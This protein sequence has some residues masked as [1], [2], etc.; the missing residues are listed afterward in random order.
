MLGALEVGDAPTDAA[1][2]T[3][4][5]IFVVQGLLLTALVSELRA[6]RRAAEHQARAA[7]AARR[8]GEAA[9]RMKD[10]FLA[11]IS[12]ELRTP[13]NAVLGWV[14]L[15]RTGKLDQASASRGLESIERNVRLQAQV[16]ADLLDVS[17]ALTGRL[18][19]ESVP[20]SL[21]DPV[22]QAVS[23][24][25]AAA[26]AK[27]VAIRSTQSDAAVVVLGDPTRLRQIAWH[28]LANAIKFTPRGGQIDI[29][30]EG[31][32]EDAQLIVRDT[33]CGIEPQF[34]PHIF[35]R[36][37]QADGSATRTSGG[38][39]V[40]LALVREL[41]ELQG[42]EIEA[43]NAPAPGGAILKVRF[44]LQSPN[45]IARRPAPEQALVFGSVPPLN[46]VRVL[47]LDQDIDGREV[48]RRLLQQRGAAVCTVSSVAEALEILE[49]W[50]PDVL[51]SDAM[52]PEHDSYALVGKV[53]SLDADRGGRIPALAL[54]TFART[55]ERLAPLLADVHRELPKPVEPAL[56]TAEI[57]RLTGRERRR[58]QR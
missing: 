40:G 19:L 52:S 49:G 56:L 14:Y 17:K 25:A 38:L 57:A 54:T 43:R 31:A 2:A 39:G 27:G 11:T 36:F 30:V 33:G 24:V 16:T 55:D 9:N 44:P 12:H 29:A 15:L 34:L 47:V 41:V 18:Q 28:L 13:L 5:A 26:R 48:L 42:G 21:V 51:V 20:T 22:Q 35:E 58:A 37:T 6:A 46:G 32:G 4:L 3:H 7:H 23:A 45:L 53:H 1:T 50:R 10:E 8:E